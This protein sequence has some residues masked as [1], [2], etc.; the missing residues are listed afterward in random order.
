MAAYLLRNQSRRGDEKRDTYIFIIEL[1]RVTIVAIVFAEGL[2]VSTQ[3][4][5]KRLLVKTSTSQPVNARA[6][7]DIAVAERVAVPPEFVV[8]SSCDSLQCRRHPRACRSH[9]YE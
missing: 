1:K 8:I 4:D 6:Q 3:N 9:G 5:P 7:R 2:A